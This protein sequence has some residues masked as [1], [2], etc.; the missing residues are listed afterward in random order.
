M[1]GISQ[2]PLHIFIM[3]TKVAQVERKKGGREGTGTFNPREY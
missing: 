3:G 2:S 1:I